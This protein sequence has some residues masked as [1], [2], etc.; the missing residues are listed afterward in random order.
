MSEVYRPVPACV[1]A[2]TALL[3]A[4]GGALFAQEAP[5]SQ[6][7]PSQESA[8]SKADP[9]SYLIGPEDVLLIRVWREPELSGTVTVRPDGKVTMQLLR[10][11]HAED[12]TPEVLAEEIRKGLEEKYLKNPQVTVT[13]VEI[14]SKKYYLQGEVGRPGAYPLLNPTTVLEALVNAGGFREF[15]NQKG[16]IVMRK[17]E[18]F[19]F[20]YKDV[21]R[22]KKMEQNILL[23]PGDIIIVP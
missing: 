17:G 1:F 15:A 11:V 16:I 19:K 5:A 21:I 13:V 7:A 18:R 8:D 9:K 23:E 20:N 14:R 22:G 3:L 4:A 10:E 6:E 12:K 2:V